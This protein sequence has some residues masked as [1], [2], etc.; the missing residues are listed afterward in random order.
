MLFRKKPKL[1]PVTKTDVVERLLEKAVVRV[2]NSNKVLVVFFDLRCPFCAKQFQESEE[3]LLDIAGKNI[4]TY[5]MCDYVVHKD[6][7]SLHKSLRCVP[8]EERLK[9]IRE[10]FNNRIVREVTCPT[11]DLEECSKLAEEVG[12]YGTPSLLFYNF[13]KGRGYIHFGYMEIDRI[14]EVISSL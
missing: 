11:N 4:V 3:V 2:G 6:A 10:V 5:A 13:S 9:F 1:T 8:A 14:L 7:V 12:I